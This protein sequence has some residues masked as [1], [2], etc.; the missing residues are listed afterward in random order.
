MIAAGEVFAYGVEDHIAIFAHAPICVAY[1]S[2]RPLRSVAIEK[3]IQQ[4]VCLSERGNDMIFFLS[5]PTRKFL[6]NVQTPPLLEVKI[7]RT[8]VWVFLLT[9]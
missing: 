8:G 9:E 5:F 3:S 6:G 7:V 2:S 1:P 4:G